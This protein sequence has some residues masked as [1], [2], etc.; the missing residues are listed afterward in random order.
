MLRL[1]EQK[2]RARAAWAG[3]G[4]DDTQALWFDIKE[5][6]GATDFLGYSADQAQAV[7]K[8]LVVD[9]KEVEEIAKGDSGQMVV[10]QTP[11]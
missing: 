11:R 7:V 5:R 4:D 9:G 3:S 8:A 6:D 2:A 1:A 10:N